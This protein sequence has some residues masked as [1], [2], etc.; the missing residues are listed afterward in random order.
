ME[1]HWL[2]Q[3]HLWAIEEVQRGSIARLL[4]SKAP[5]LYFKQT[6]IAQKELC[7]NPR[8]RRTWDV[9]KKL[10]RRNAHFINSPFGLYAVLPLSIQCPQALPSSVFSSPFCQPSPR[11][12]PTSIPLPTSH[13]PPDTPQHAK[14]YN[15]LKFPSTT[16][17]L[18]L[19][20]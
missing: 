8:I 10:R 20:V 2:T 1:Q 9:G 6:H 17:K 13:P 7:Q 18:G 16:P 12:Q 11:P 3:D 19:L 15:G 14:L 4:R 5:G